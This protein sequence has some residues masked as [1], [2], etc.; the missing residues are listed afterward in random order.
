MSFPP[1]CCKGWKYIL[2]I[3]K[4]W[5]LAWL[6]GVKESHRGISN[7]KYVA[8]KIVDGII[9]GIIYFKLCYEKYF[10][11]RHSRS[12]RYRHRIL[13]GNWKRWEFRW[14]F[15]FRFLTIVALNSLLSARTLMALLLDSN[16][17]T[18]N[19]VNQLTFL[20]IYIFN[21]FILLHP[22]FYFSHS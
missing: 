7:M 5:F 6:I 21:D 20:Y 1:V 9:I 18:D 17:L 13:P 14:C 4:T 12:H 10:N 8:G 3:L 19:Y 22:S 16:W 15:C 11:F 2:G